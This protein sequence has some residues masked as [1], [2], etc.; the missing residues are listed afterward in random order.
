M[1]Q[2]D[3]IQAKFNVADLERRPEF[4]N[5]GAGPC[6][7]SAVP[8]HMTDGMKPPPPANNRPQNRE[9]PTIAPGTPLRSVQEVDDGDVLVDESFEGEFVGM[10]E[11]LF[12]EVDQSVSVGAGGSR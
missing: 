8:S 2:A 3:V 5:A 1:G 7:A 11:A 4:T 12:D 10:E 9:S 6:R